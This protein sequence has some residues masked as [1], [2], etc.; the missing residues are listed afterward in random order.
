MKE[1][2][3][4]LNFLWSG[5]IEKHVIDLFHHSMTLHIRVI[6]GGEESN[7]LLKFINVKA[8][9]YFND[10]SP[11]EPEVDDFLELTSVTYLPEKEMQIKVSDISHACSHLQTKVNFSLEIWG[12]EMIIEAS[13]VEIDGLLF[14]VGFS[15]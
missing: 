14:N 8:F 11:F 12:R 10:Q 15:Q 6:N 4:Y 13:A 9:Y 1:V 5:T 3:N 2:Q 7:H